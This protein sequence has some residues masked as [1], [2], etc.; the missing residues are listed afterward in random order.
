MNIFVDL[1]RGVG[2]YPLFFMRYTM[3]NHQN[4]PYKIAS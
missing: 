2:L 1:N 3:Q 4:R